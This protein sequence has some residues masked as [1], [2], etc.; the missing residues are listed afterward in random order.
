MAKYAVG[1]YICQVRKE[2]GYT[3]EELSE[4]ICTTGTL[5]KI[6]NGSR[7]PSFSTYEAL[8][9][10]L[11]KPASFFSVYLGRRELEAD[12]YCRGMI[13]LLSRDEKID[14]EVL[15]QE[16]AAARM[17]FRLQESPIMLCLKAVCHSM[18]GDP[19]R[20]VLKE[21]YAA[22]R[23][24]EP[25]DDESL[26]VQMGRLLT[27][28]EMTIWNNIAIQY[29]RM[30]QYKRAHAIWS[31]LCE[32]LNER[33]VDSEERANL[34]PIIVYNQAELYALEHVYAEAIQNSESGISVCVEFGKLFPLPYLL[35][36][37]GRELKE[38]GDQHASEE[39]IRKSELL[40][41]IMNKKPRERTTEFP[42]G[43]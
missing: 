31:G 25:A 35:W 8:M 13:R 29:K 10:R 3:Q 18:S 9:Q 17:K 19:P 21:L 37:K 24:R 7:A 4:G 5:S 39:Y 40:W 38:L 33:E 12:N 27:F 34:Y 28:D 15:L 11:G 41:N 23:V 43:F 26:R 1:D 20:Q 30:K 42:A 16:Y 6:E 2:R 14:P 32:Y 22:L 36:Q